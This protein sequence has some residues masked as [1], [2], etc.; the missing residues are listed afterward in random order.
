MGYAVRPGRVRAH[1]HE[2]RVRV[3]VDDLV[4]ELRNLL[5]VGALRR[6]RIRRRHPAA[7]SAPARPRVR[8]AIRSRGSASDVDGVAPRA[9]SAETDSRAEAGAKQAPL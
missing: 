9:R 3:R 6:A 4:A 8:R 7:A 1:A 5:A 2:P